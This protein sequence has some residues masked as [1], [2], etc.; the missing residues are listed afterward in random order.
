MGELFRQLAAQR[1]EFAG[2]VGQAGAGHQRAGL[3]RR[4]LLVHLAGDDR[5]ALVQLLLLGLAQVAGGQGMGRPAHGQTGQRL[6]AQARC[7]PC[8][9][10][11]QWQGER[12]GG[13][14]CAQHG[15]LPQ[16]GRD[17]VHGAHE[18]FKRRL[19]GCF[20]RTHAGVVGLDQALGESGP[21]AAA[22]FQV[23]YI[24][25]EAVA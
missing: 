7:E 25:I 17:V 2:A 8:H 22:V 6:Q 18:L 23:A 20:L 21:G 12:G 4:Q 9:A 19:G 1:R 3:Q 5:R 14:L 24:H 11:A 16:G 10:G 15:R 13:G